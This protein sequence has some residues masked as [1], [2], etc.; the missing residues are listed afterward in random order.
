M[1]GNRNARADHP[2][3]KMF[4]NSLEQFMRHSMSMRQLTSVELVNTYWQHSHKIADTGR[5]SFIIRGNVSWESDQLDGI[6]SKSLWLKTNRFDPIGKHITTDPLRTYLQWYMNLY[7]IWGTININI[8]PTD[9]KIS[10]PIIEKHIERIAGI[11]NAMSLLFSASLHWI[12][13]L[14]SEITHVPLP[15]LPHTDEYKSWDCT[16]LRRS[17]DEHIGI[18]V[19]VNISYIT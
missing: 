14:Y 4:G 6:S 19:K 8:D 1:S 13:A 15:S 7:E 11:T 17:Q 3:Q 16:P 18:E 12:P 5:M 10:K 9:A 2:G